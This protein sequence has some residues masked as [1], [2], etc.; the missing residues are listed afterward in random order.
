MEASKLP[1]QL[2]RA[3]F[4]REGYRRPL[5]PNRAQCRALATTHHSPCTSVRLAGCRA[6]PRAT[7]GKSPTLLTD[8]MPQGS[9]SKA[10]DLKSVMILDAEL[11]QRH[12]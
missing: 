11:V 3:F 6:E 12:A 5:R 4:P 7:V 8:F 1:I 2:E 10:C 9:T